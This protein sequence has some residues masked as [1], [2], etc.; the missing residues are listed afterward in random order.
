MSIERMRWNEY[1][2]NMQMHFNRLNSIRAL[3]RPSFSM[4]SSRFPH[5]SQNPKRD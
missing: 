2:R 5:L 4:E 1:N 3:E